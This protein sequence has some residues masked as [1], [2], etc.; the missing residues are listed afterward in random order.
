MIYR[1][2]SHTSNFRPAMSLGLIL[3]ESVSNYL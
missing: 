1:I 3:P 2:H